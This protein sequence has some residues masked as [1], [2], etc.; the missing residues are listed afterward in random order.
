MG[1]DVFNHTDVRA[2]TKRRALQLCVTQKKKDDTTTSGFVLCNHKAAATAPPPEAIQRA[3]IDLSALHVPWSRVRRFILSWLPGGQ[4]NASLPSLFPV[5]LR[6]RAG[7][8]G[9]AHLR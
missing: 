2:S 7:E 8:A 5:L 3:I 4:V 1:A 9:K 6:S